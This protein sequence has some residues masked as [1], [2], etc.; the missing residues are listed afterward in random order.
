[1]ED[2]PSQENVMCDLNAYLKHQDKE[3]LILESV[4]Q[5]RTEGDEVVL[6]NLFGEERRV[7]GDISEVSLTRSRVVITPR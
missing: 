4:N 3:E 5:L 1:M 2:V 6:R 7:R